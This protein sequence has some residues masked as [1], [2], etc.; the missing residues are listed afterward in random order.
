MQWAI[1]QH[2]QAT[3]QRL[4]AEGVK[5]AGQALAAANAG[6]SLEARSALRRGPEAYREHQAATV[7]DSLARQAVSRGVEAEEIRETASPGGDRVAD[8]AA[9]SADR[10]GHRDSG[11]DLLATPDERYRYERN[12][13]GTARITPLGDPAA[14][15][16]ISRLIAA[17]A[18]DGWPADRIAV[19]LGIDLGRGVVRVPDLTVWSR[20]PQESRAGL[21]RLD[22]LDLIVEVET[23]D[24]TATIAEYAAVGVPACWIIGLDGL[25]RCHVLTPA[26]GYT[27]A[28]P[29]VPL[30]VLLAAPPDS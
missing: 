30:D 11:P 28:G 26:D 17:L 21:A 1:E 22:G 4:T 25:A 8:L 7:A 29:P 23:P 10:L 2:Y 6:L 18:A 20:S 9:E 3:G 15:M 27:Q 12:A 19:N 24:R 16:L 13:D 14:A 5:A